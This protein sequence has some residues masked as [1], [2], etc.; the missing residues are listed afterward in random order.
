MS[1]DAVVDRLI[2]RAECK[3][4]E[5]EY[6]Y[7]FGVSLGLLQEDLAVMASLETAKMWFVRASTTANEY[8]EGKRLSLDGSYDL[9]TACSW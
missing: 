7:R 9:N 3:V 2:S 1:Q 6:L 4:T 5:L 8:G